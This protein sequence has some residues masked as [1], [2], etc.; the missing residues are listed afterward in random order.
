MKY[1]LLFCFDSGNWHTI[2][3]IPRK[4]NF[5]SCWDEHGEAFWALLLFCLLPHQPLFTPL[6]T[7]TCTVSAPPRQ[8]LI[9][10]DH[11]SSTEGRLGWVPAMREP[12]CHLAGSY[13]LWCCPRF[14]DFC[15][16]VK[17]I[18]NLSITSLRILHRVKNDT[19]VHNADTFEIIRFTKSMVIRYLRNTTIVFV[20]VS[21]IL[22]WQEEIK[23]KGKGGLA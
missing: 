11:A 6:S 19:V 15:P 23:A 9:W 20:L 17:Y 8:R 2:L 14:S 1:L 22:I 13:D 18:E 4:I 7:H 5:D 10:R 3:V 21:L 16:L 12:S